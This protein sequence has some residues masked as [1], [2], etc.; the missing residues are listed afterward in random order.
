MLPTA[1]LHI[2]I[3][4][5]LE[6]EQLVQLARRNGI[7]LPTYDVATLRETYVFSQLQDFLDVYYENLGVLRTAE[8]FHDLAAAYLARARTAGVRHAEIFFDPQVHLG[9]GVPAGAVFEGLGAAL[10]EARADGMSA[11]L[12]MC[13][14]RDRGPDEAMSMLEAAL[15]YRGRFIGVGLDSAEVGY[16]PSLF[17]DVFDRAAAEGLHRVAHAGEEG[18]PDYVWEALDL[19]HVERVDHGNRALEDDAL[20]QRLRSDGI[21]LTVCPLSNLALRTAPPALAEHPLP[22]MLEE[23]LIVSVH[24]DDPAYFGGYIDDNVRAVETQLGLSAHQ[25]GQLAKNA[26]RSSFAPADRVAAWIAEVDQ[27]LEHAEAVAHEIG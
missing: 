19:L 17:V 13:F 16:P 6:P 23:G 21:P 7:A 25:M 3:E 8:D 4:G 14:L 18:G 10:D 12:I 1:E 24:S 22:V 11:E 20:V 2:H 15:P 26:F 27:A 9:R 5:S